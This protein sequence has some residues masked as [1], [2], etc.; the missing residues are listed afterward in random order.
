MRTGSI[1]VDIVHGLVGSAVGGEFERPVLL[2]E[3]KKERATAKKGQ[4]TRSAQGASSPRP[5]SLSSSLSHPQRR[6]AHAHTHRVPRHGWAVLFLQAGIDGGEGE[7]GQERGPGESQLERR[8]SGLQWDR[9]RRTAAVRLAR[10][11]RYAGLTVVARRAQPVGAEEGGGGCRSC[12][13]SSSS[14]VSFFFVTRSRSGATDPYIH[15]HSYIH[16]EREREEHFPAHAHTVKDTHITQ[17]HKH[18]ANTPLTHTHTH[19]AH[20][21]THTHT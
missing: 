18:I 19:H 9:I 14:R 10:R 12:L 16:R 21:H 4:P 17:S 13:V 6:S 7:T 3:A 20:T 5:S 8:A 11:T 15:A 1:G 2:R